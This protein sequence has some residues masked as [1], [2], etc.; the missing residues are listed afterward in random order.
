M[1]TPPR[2]T[3]PRAVVFDVGNVLI[4]WQPDR[5]YSRL[6][7]DPAERA[8]FFERLE[9][10]AM[11]L[12][13][14]R[15]DLAAQVAAHAARHPAEAPLI[16][17]WR[18]DWPEMFGPEMPGAAALFAA[19][20]AAGVTVAALTN[21]ARDTWLVGQGMFPLLTGFDAEI[22]SGRE[23][24]VKPEPRIYEIVEQRLGLAGA[25][26]FFTDDKEKNTAAAAARGWR[27]HHF[28]GSEG[29]AAALRAEG[30]A[31]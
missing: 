23:G 20:K 4:D 14:D 25:D 6:I 31:I 9:I 8:A 15:G 26:L 13:G 10:P 17:A 3:P 24:C 16:R 21:F 29:L 22:V 28:Q 7:P 12:E 27:V 19:V 5:L 18:E 2:A 1:P 30:L 11:N